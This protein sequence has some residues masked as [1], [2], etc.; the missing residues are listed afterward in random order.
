MAIKVCFANQKGGVGKSTT[1]QQFCAYFANKGKHVL[2]VDLDPQWNLTM[3]YGVMSDEY[4]KDGDM[5]GQTIY[6]VF[7]GKP[8]RD[9]VLKDV[10][11]NT[12]L[13]SGSMLI[14][15][16]DGE[17][18]GADGFVK[19]K[20]A[21]R[22]IENDYDLIVIDCPPTVG[23]LTVNALVACDGVVI[24]YKADSLTKAST[25]QLNKTIETVR[26]IFN[27]GLKIYGVLMTMFDHRT[28]ISQR[29][30]LDAAEVAEML[31]SKVFASK[32][33]TSAKVRELFDEAETIFDF[34]PTSTVAEDYRGFCMEFEKEYM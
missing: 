2:V 4:E 3:M 13:I 31:K 32:I 1:A 23:L 7:K 19:V 30:V 10:Q 12:D 33:R 8:V 21:I 25:V 29:S 34:A 6:Q 26:E 18:Q 24:P 17:F 22:P 11:P 15:N 16:A 28:K 5:S 14:S 9:V 20:Q 27:P